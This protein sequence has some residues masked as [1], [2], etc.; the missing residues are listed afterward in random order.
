MVDKSSG[1]TDNL[2]FQLKELQVRVGEN[3]SKI[4]EN[5]GKIKEL[6][7]NVGD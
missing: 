1:F 4:A 7:S 2:E 3:S 5:A 6:D